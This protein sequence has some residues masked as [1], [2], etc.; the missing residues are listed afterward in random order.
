[1]R[2][3]V[4]S[5]GCAVAFILSVLS[6]PAGEKFSGE[7]TLSEVSERTVRI[8]FAPLHEHGNPQPPTAT[9]ILVP[10]PSTKKLSTR[11]LDAEKEVRVGQLRA[12]IRPQ[13]LTI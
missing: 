7:L 13:P 8:Q 4:P 2:S 10:F 12:T 3:I 6:L 5:C 11:E 9:T 1:M